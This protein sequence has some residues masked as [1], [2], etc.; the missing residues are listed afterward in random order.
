MIF[1]ELEKFVTDQLGEGAWGKLTK[2]AGIAPGRTYKP[3]FMYPDEELVV[4]VQTGSK[5]TGIPVPALLEA[6]GEFIAPAFLE[7][8]WKAIEPSWQ[9]LDVIENTE[10]AIH[11]V[12][13][14]DH[15]GALPPYLTAQRTGPNE[16]AVTYT[17]PRKLCFV[18]KGIC[19]G[20]A[21]HFGESIEIADVRCM[22]RGDADCLMVIRTTT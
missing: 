8:Y 7:L 22:H 4:L 15:P 18:G 19:R 5:V 21:R 14:L 9:T 17:S 2:E 12:V 10:A 13:R 16:V 1:V 11:T 20:I 3:R 6:F